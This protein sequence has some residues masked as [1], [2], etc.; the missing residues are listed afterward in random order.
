MKTICGGGAAEGRGIKN[1]SDSLMESG[2]HNAS[3]ESPD[4]FLQQFAREALDVVSK[5]RHAS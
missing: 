1:F 5:S 2:V 4:R 3:F